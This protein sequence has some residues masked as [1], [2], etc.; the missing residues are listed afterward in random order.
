MRDW[1]QDVGS[2]N[3]QSRVLLVCGV[4]QLVRGWLFYDTENMAWSHV[5]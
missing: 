4:L 1:S 5:S 3:S 2:L